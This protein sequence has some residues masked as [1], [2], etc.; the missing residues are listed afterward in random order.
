MNEASRAEGIGA[1]LLLLLFELRKILLNHGC[2]SGAGVFQIFAQFGCFFVAIAFCV[3]NLREQKMHTRIRMIAKMSFPMSAIPS[4]VIIS[5]FYQHLILV[6]IIV[7]IFQF[8]GQFVS[9]HY[10]MLPYFMFAT[11]ALIF[12]FSLI[13]STLSTIIRDV[14]MVVQSLLR[15]LIYMTPILWT[16]EGVKGWVRDILVLNPL[17]YIVDGYRASLLGTSWYPVTHWHYTIY[18]WAVILVFMLIGSVVHVKFR[19]R[20]VDFL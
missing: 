1:S 12:S 10:I 2:V 20:F 19:D 5:K 17:W 3:V 16:M 14:Q 8:M 11:I 6:G 4:F 13:T 18:F 7:I 9:I 15:V